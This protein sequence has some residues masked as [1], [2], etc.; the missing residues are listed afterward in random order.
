MNSEINSKA[1]SSFKKN[2]KFTFKNIE[3]PN[4]QVS[5]KSQIWKNQ[6]SSKGL[7]TLRLVAKGL[8]VWAIR[9]SVFR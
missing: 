1:M 4:F 5:K 3:V 7:P 9:R 2:A 8:K 6:K